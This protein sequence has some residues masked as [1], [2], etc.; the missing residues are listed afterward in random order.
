[1]VRADLIGGLGNNMFQYIIARSIADAKNYNL[2]VADIGKMQQYFKNVTNINDR[3]SKDYNVLRVG[4]GSQSGMVQYFDKTNVLQHD[5][6]I[7][8]SGFFQ[9][10]ILYEDL[11]DA[12]KNYFKY[13]DENHAKPGEDD[14]V[15]HVRLG[16]YTA[17][18]WFLHPELFVKIIEDNNIKYDKCFIV[19]DDPNHQLLLTFFKLKNVH[20]LNQ[21]VLEDFTFL[22]A[23]KQLIISQSTFS[24]WSA[25]LG[26]AHKVFVP[27]T[28]SFT[29]PWKK[30]PGFDDIDLVMNNNKFIKISV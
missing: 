27:L 11:M 16:D 19:T 8:F 30:L 7:T 13:D 29:H 18:N 4:Y 14:L 3:I 20:I 22:T 17:L 26:N 1:M 9:K 21:S 25:M 15:I 10:S 28:D 5:G 23:A 6:G 2:Q 24:W 12:A